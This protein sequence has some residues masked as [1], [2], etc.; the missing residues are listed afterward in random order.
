MQYQ[1]PESLAARMRPEAEMF[2]RASQAT[3]LQNTYARS[4][5]RVTPVDTLLA[6]ITLARSFGHDLP[7]SALNRLDPIAA[8]AAAAAVA[9]PH[10]R[11]DVPVD[12]LRWATDVL[13]E[14]ITEPSHTE[15]VASSFYSLGADRSAATGLAGAPGRGIR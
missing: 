15:Y 9:H 1:H 10:G 8:V 7:D 2:S 4:D 3:R 11:I 6:D 13:I 5:D 14:A 12:D